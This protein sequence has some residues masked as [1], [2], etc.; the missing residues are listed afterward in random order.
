MTILLAKDQRYCQLTV[1]QDLFGQFYITR[2]SGKINRNGVWCKSF[3]FNDEKQAM[4]KL[5][6]LENSKRRQEFKY[7]D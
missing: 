3:Y 1:E 7:I 2:S 5:F 4:Q 6:E